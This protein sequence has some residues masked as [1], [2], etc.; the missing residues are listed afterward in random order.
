VNVIFAGGPAFV[1][2]AAAAWVTVEVPMVAC[3]VPES[4]AW[5]LGW[6]VVL[7]VP[8]E[9]VDPDEG[10]KLKAVEAGYPVT[11]HTTVSPVSTP[12]TGHPEPDVHVTVA[13]MV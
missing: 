8:V 5:L 3:T 6:N 7:V 1:T 12:D 11:D 4:V 10:V 9:S 2:I 13:A